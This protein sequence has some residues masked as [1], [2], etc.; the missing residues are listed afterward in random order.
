MIKG[1]NKKK[2]SISQY[3]KEMFVETLIVADKTMVDKFRNDDLEN[4]LLTIMNMVLI[5]F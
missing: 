4:Y 3:K 5:H 2:R 1:V